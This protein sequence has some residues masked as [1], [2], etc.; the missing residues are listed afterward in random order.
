[1]KVLEIGGGNNPKYCGKFGNGINL[2]V[3]PLPTVDVVHD[4]NKPLPFDNNKFD[5]V[6]SSYLLEHLSW[7]KVKQFIKEIYRILRPEGRAEIITANTY[8]QCKKIVEEGWNDNSSCMLFGD[9][10]YEFNV[11]KCGF[12]PEYA[13]KLFKEAGF[14]KVD[15]SPHPE[16]ETDMIIT[17]YKKPPETV[18][19]ASTIFNREYFE[20]GTKGYRLYR[21]FPSNYKTLEV[22]L[23]RKP[24]SVL[25]LGCARA[26]IVK[27]L[28]DRGIRA[29]GVDVSLHCWHTRVTD[30]FV[31]YDVTKVP[32]P[33]GDKEFDLCFSKDFMEHLPEDKLPVIIK[34]MARVCKRALHGITFSD[35]PFAKDDP[36]HK[37][38]KPKEWWIQLF[39]QHTPMFPVE[40]IDK[41]E[42]ERGPIKPESDGLV[43]LNIGCFLDM[44][45]YGWVNIDIQDLSEWAKAN[46]YVF[47]QLDVLKG[48]FY[49]DDGVD[50][51]LAS[52]FIEHLTREEGLRF[53]RECHRVLKPNGL[54][55][56]VVPDAKLLAEKYLSG[57]IM[58]YHHVNIGVEKAKDDTEALFHLLLAGHKTIYDFK[59][60]KRLLKE[61]GFTSIK[62]MSP[63]Q[64]QSEAI[65][66]QTIPLYPTL[67]LYVEAKPRKAEVTPKVKTIPKVSSKLKIGLISTPFLRTPPS[68]Y[69]GLE[70]IVANLGEVLSKM[71]HEVTVFAADGSKVEG[72]KIIEFGPPKLKVQVDWLK[73]E[74]EAYLKIEDM[75]QE[76]D[77]IHGHNWLGFEYLAKAKNSRL[78][79][80]HTHH[81]HLNLEWWG[82]SKPPFKLNLI[83][84]S[85]WMRKIYEAQGF[86]AKFVYNGINLE[87]Y[88]FKKEKGDRLLFVGRIDKF[89]Q[90]DVAIQVAR[91][92]H[93]GL[94]IVGGTFVQDPS[95]LAKIQSLCDGEQI[96]FYADASHKKKI[97]LMQNAKCLLFPSKMG[98]PFGLVPVEAMACGTPVVA[99]NDGAVEE[100]VREGGIVCNVFDKQITSK[101]PVYT[102]KLDPID[103]LCEAISQVDSISAEDCRKN[104]QRFPREKMAKAYVEL[105]KHIL[106]GKEW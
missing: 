60:L 40:I 31:L 76:F 98:E 62:Q 42:M 63:F 53:L 24:E 55:R 13:I 101:G 14:D 1:L 56:L 85:D 21:D 69:G 66:K 25:E 89:K 70:L 73:S 35:H 65:E 2:D 61:A 87:H 95:Y 8:E 47:R 48:L 36:T 82:R 64:S 26:Y 32:W 37:T 92:L 90:P 7:R 57:E 81:G 50:I 96:K 67:S 58:E 93:T 17:V 46:G 34:E 18:K 102:E 10:N 39:K 99:L 59:S 88:P 29:V 27:K 83:A 51:I 103:A 52:H 91:K 19:E 54:I 41:E 44:F 79:V 74:R 105:Y 16:C 30:S 106:S 104:A 38:L 97:E 20:D 4:V 71:G 9:Q 80:C 49:K 84:I 12:S 11:H 23:E 15:V 43:K 6:Y 72:C 33:F 45:H 100:V 68:T 77:I 75:L 94:D 28:E 5:Y 3:R 22:I 78:K 86:P